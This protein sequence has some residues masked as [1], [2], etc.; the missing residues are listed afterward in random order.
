[1]TFACQVQNV[2]IFWIVAKF[3]QHKPDDTAH[4]DKNK[5]QSV[6]LIDIQWPSSL[7][8]TEIWMMQFAI[9]ISFVIQSSFIIALF[10]WIS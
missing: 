10:A 1:M 2:S 8:S 4:L 3:T 7:V 5:L 9:A 6:S